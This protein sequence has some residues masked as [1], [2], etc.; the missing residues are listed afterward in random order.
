MAGRAKKS[1]GKKTS[2]PKGASGGK[3]TG[4]SAAKSGGHPGCDLSDVDVVII[5]R[6]NKSA[7]PVKAWCPVGGIVAFYNR[8]KQDR[9]VSFDHSPFVKSMGAQS[10]AVPDGECVKKTVKADME[11]GYPYK[12]TPPLRKDTGGSPPDPPE[13]VVGDEE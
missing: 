10:F 7:S 8:S 2:G 1:A 12:V 3:K 11:T 6:Q 13:V 5:F 4:G 9:T